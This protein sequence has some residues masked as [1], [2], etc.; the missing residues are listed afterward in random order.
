MESEEMHA[1]SL[2]SSYQLLRAVE[3][4][5]VVVFVPAEIVGVDFDDLGNEVPVEMH[6]R[7]C[8]W[9]CYC[10]ERTSD[11][12]PAICSLPAVQLRGLPG[13]IPGGFGQ[14]FLGT[15]YSSCR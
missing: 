13:A 12:G 2:R 15:V 3:N 6:A 4:E 8:L 11:F 7:V 10:N 9:S 5:A 1:G 14:T